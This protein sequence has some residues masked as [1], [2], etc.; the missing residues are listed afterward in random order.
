MTCERKKSKK[1]E[2]PQWASPPFY[3]RLVFNHLV[4]NKHQRKAGRAVAYR[5]LEAVGRVGKQVDLCTSQV[6]DEVEV[7]EVES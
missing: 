6:V 4:G 2:I 1:E 7:I 3:N 5:G